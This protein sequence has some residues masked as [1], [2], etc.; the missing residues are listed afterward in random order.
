MKFR[1]LEERIMAREEELEAVRAEMATEAVFLDPKKL[2][3][4]QARE[5]ELQAALEA[6]YATWENWG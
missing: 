1:E 5:A 3:A 4:A 2:R 6:D